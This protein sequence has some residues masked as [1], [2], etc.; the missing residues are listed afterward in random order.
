MTDCFISYTK[1]DEHL[2]EYVAEHL[3]A[4][5]ISVFL[6]CTSVRP[7]A[8]WTEEVWDNLRTS[9]WVIFLASKK[10]CKSAFVQQ[11]LGYAIGAKKRIVPV[12]WDIDPSKLPGWVI[13]HHA[14]DL[15]SCGGVQGLK[16]HI[17][18]I[19]KAI[20][21]TKSLGLLI[22]GAVFVGLLVAKL[23]NSEPNEEP[24]NQS[25]HIK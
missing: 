5:G 16:A 14:I 2:A 20:N 12:V 10:A 3:I 17:G 11:E 7:G 1:A 9:S 19:A 23:F 24:N 13:K 15:R 8:T 22:I 18:S 4:D 21:A 25:K 6:A